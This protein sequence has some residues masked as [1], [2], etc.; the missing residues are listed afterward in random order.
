MNRDLPPGWEWVELGEICREDRIAVSSTDVAYDEMPYLGLEHVE[1]NT[2]RILVTE[3]EA[4]L[5]DSVSNNFRFTTEHVLYG[6]LRPYLNKVA[7]P[8]FAGR[9]TT[10]IVPLL[11]T[12]ADR[13]WLAWL[14]RHGDTVEYA[15][16]GKTGSRMPRTDMRRLMRLPVALPPKEEQRKIAVMMADVER[17]RSVA[18]KQLA[19]IDDLSAALLR[20]IF[21]RSPAAR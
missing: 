8:T 2:G 18:T 13:Q 12:S 20:E 7:L 17:A 21:P 14:L 3:D 9:C 10:E 16:Q 4:R 6:K 5:S 1:S 15:M 11:A 19:T